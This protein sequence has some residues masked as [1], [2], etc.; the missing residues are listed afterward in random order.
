LQDL[1]QNV[2]KLKNGAIKH[3]Y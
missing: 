2:F 1:Q 3:Q